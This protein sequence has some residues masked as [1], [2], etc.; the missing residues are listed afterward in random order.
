MTDKNHNQTP[1]FTWTRNKAFAAG[2]GAVAIVGSVFAVPAIAESRYY[3]HAEIQ[4]SSGDV[5]VTKAG[6][7]RSSQERGLAGMS[8]EQIEKRVT[9]MVRHFAVEIDATDAQ[10]D[11]IKEVAL[12][13]ALDMKPLRADY[14][15]AGEALANLLTADQVDR[16]AIEAIR[17]ERM[18][19]TDAVSQK[20]LTAM[21][22]VSEIL[23]VEQRQELA[24][25]VEKIKAR[26]AD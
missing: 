16:A 7:G 9:K 21:T 3:Q 10:Q 2:L 15:A 25:R 17:A 8:D 1:K 19:A 6:W 13:T 11:K 4:F 20:L 5:Q 18:A 12:A 22:D 26:W 14:R 24:E 23:T